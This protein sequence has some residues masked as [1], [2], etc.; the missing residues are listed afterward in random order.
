M[1]AATSSFAHQRWHHLQMWPQKMLKQGWWKKAETRLMKGSWNKADEGK[2]KQS[3]WRE[4][5]TRLMKGS[6]WRE[7]ETKLMKGSWNKADE[8]R[9]SKAN[10]A[11]L[12]L[13]PSGP[14]EN[15]H[16]VW[17]VTI[18]TIGTSCMK[19]GRSPRL[20]HSSLASR[21][22]WIWWC[23]CSTKPGPW[24]ANLVWEG[25]PWMWHMLNAW[26]SV[27]SRKEFSYLT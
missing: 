6:W 22:S 23:A 8:E 1:V 10:E 14:E 27:L 15:M 16:G 26:K 19:S 5:E 13:N 21:W 12:K 11:K 20:A 9:W 18:P 25:H 4:A 3:W 2:L 7:A 17:C 24:G